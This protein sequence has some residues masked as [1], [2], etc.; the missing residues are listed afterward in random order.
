[1]RA[2]GHTL[3]GSGTAG[4][5]WTYTLN[6]GT[7]TK[8]GRLRFVTGQITLGAI[9]SGA[10]GSVIIKGLPD[11]VNAANG[12][13]GAG[14][15]SGLQNMS[16]S[17]VDIGLSPVVGTTDIAIYHKTAAATGDTQ[18]AISDISATFTLSFSV[19]YQV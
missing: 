5:G 10:A 3:E 12:F 1:M 19:V 7:V 13:Q 6:A 4:T 16:T 11:T 8:I 14:M 9:G 15:V 18:T 2:L 17:V